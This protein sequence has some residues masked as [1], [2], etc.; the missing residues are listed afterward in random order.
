MK[1]A[2]Y[3]EFTILIVDDEIHLTRAY[4]ITLNYFKPVGLEYLVIGYDVQV[5]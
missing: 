3:P 5:V 4:E 1:E 2:L